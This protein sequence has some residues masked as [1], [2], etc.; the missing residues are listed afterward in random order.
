MV[1][2]SV[3]WLRF[4]QPWTGKQRELGV[5]AYPSGWN[6]PREP[7][8]TIRTRHRDDANE[9]VAGSWAVEFKPDVLGFSM[10]WKRSDGP[11]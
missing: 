2:I 3:G 1:V 9:I 10:E 7:R 6:R 8:S 11:S 5:G 4:A